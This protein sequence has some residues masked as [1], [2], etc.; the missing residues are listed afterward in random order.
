MKF[1]IE[2]TDEGQVTA[3]NVEDGKCSLDELIAILF[4]VMDAA[5]RKVLENAPEEVVDFT[6]EH[7]NGIFD[8]FLRKVFPDP[9]EGYFELSDAALL[10]AQDKIIDEAEKKGITFKEA[11]EKY[12]KRATEYVRQKKEGLS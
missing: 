1:I 7:F 9:P 4:E 3:F 6:Y 12:E 8:L 11:L 5:T 2:A 10:Y